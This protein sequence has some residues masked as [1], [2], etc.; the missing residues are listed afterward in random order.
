MEIIDDATGEVVWDTSKL[1][2]DNTGLVGVSE[3]GYHALLPDE[4]RLPVNGISEF[5]KADGWLGFGGTGVNYQADLEV[6][7][8]VERSE[9]DTRQY[10]WENCTALLYNEQSRP[11]FVYL[12]QDDYYFVRVVVANRNTGTGR[13]RSS[14]TFDGMTFWPS[15]TKCI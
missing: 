15:D 8:D 10:L 9:R 7:D 4:D 3:C 13:R 6:G 5:Y 11:G 2:A 1:I 12:R 14:S